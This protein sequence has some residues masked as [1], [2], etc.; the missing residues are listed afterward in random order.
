MAIYP[1]IPGQKPNQRHV[2][3]PHSPT[4]E[5]NKQLGNI[6]DETE[7][8]EN[9]QPAQP[10]Q[11]NLIDF[12]EPPAQQPISPPAAPVP[13]PVHVLEPSPNHEISNLLNSTGKPAEGPLIDFTEDLKK[14][15]PSDTRR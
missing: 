12:S 4:S 3:P 1:V 10:A 9:R 11:D 14:D 13:A 7:V 8:R 6:A 5:A 15:L 2:I